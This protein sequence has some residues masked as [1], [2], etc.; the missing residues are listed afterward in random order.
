MPILSF[1]ITNLYLCSQIHRFY[2]LSMPIYYQW[3]LLTESAIFMFVF[4]LIIESFVNY[5]TNN[6]P[7]FIPLS[8]SFE[9]N[10]KIP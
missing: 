10:S 1:V 9:N 4:R 7:F 2:P 8:L 6:F 3:H 5:S